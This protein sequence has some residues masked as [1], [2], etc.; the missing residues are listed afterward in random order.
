MSDQ[1]KGLC[2]ALLA[3]LGG[4]LYAIPYRLSLENVAPMTV[5]WG[6]FLWAFLFSL[7]GAWFA[8]RQKIISAA[9]KYCSVDIP[10]PSPIFR[11]RRQAQKLSC[12]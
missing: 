7:P 4:G 3:M 6:V 5:I 1:I 9:G 11:S 12:S 10:Q 2:F 8:R